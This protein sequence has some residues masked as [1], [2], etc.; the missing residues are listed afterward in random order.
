MNPIDTK[1]ARIYLE[2][3]IKKLAKSHKFKYNNLA[4]KNQKTRWGSCSFKNNINLNAKLLHLPSK[5]IDYVI[6]HELVHTIV[7]N[8]SKDFW[9]MLSLYF[10]NA[11]A[12]DKELKKYRL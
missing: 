8:H 12:C 3:R 1:Y 4:I 6:M 2:E 7:K 10:P 9:D 11:R 5:L